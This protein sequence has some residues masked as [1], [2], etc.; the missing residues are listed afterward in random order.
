MF[1]ISRLVAAVPVLAIHGIAGAQ[2]SAAGNAVAEQLAQSSLRM[3]GSLLAV[4][5]VVALCSW[6]L[7]RWRDR[8]NISNESIEIISGLSLGSKDRIVLLRIG[9]EQVLV[10]VSPAGMQSLHVMQQPAAGA[11][12][13]A[14]EIS[15]DLKADAVV[16][17]KPLPPA[18]KLSMGAAQ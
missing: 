2:E 16:Q 1:A 18:F 17:A 5:T 4:L 3:V 11:R 15:G 6:G 10:G 8:Q 12:A 9:D 14:A 7:R 13:Q